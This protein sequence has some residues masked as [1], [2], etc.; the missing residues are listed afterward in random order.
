LARVGFNPYV[1]GDFGDCFGRLF[2][3][4]AVTD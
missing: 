4:N 3:G 2:F 1:L